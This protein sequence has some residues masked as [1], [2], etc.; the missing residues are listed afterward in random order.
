MSNERCYT[1][2]SDD[3]NTDGGD[4]PQQAGVRITIAADDCRIA[5]VFE[6]L[7]SRIATGLNQRPNLPDP[8]DRQIRAGERRQRK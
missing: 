1:K 4:T 2:D 8:I 7:C 3:E 5:V 6:L